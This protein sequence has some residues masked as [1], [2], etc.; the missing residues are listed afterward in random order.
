MSLHQMR[1]MKPLHKINVL[2]LTGRLPGPM[3]TYHLQ[4]M[5]A[6][7]F[8]VEVPNREDPFLNQDL[9]KMAPLFFE[10]YQ[11]LNKDKVILN[12]PLSSLREKF[13]DKLDLV[14]TTLSPS[15]IRALG[16]DE[17]SDLFLYVTSDEKNSGMHD[18]N[19]LARLGILSLY[20]TNKKEPV[21]SPPFLPIAGVSFSYEIALTAL[22]HL[23]SKKRGQKHIQISMLDSI[24]SGLTPLLPSAKLMQ[25]KHLHNGLF[26]CYN[27]YRLKDGHYAA[28]ACVEEHYFLDFCEAF[29]LHLPAESRF[30]TTGKVTKK[31]SKLFN[32]LTYEE[33]LIK[34]SSHDYCLSLIKNPME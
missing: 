22:S 17:V 13:K 6:N 33:L 10:W 20:I 12:L 9:K 25:Q 4:K 8:K 3:A 16:L 30:D 29:K 31:L 1:A 34:T 15:K 32:E 21:V 27:L 2:D 7:V 18:L 19:A 28:L 24:E 14:V 11:N 26:P 5:G 23:I